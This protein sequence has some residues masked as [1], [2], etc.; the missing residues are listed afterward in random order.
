MIIKN[1]DQPSVYLRQ[2][3][4]LNRR[5]AGHHP[6]K[7]KV[8]QMYR[9]HYSGYLGER[10]LHYPLSFIRHKPYA[11]LFDVRLEDFNHTYFQI[12]CLLLTPHFILVLEAKNLSGSFVYNADF[13]FLE[14]VKDEK[15]SAMNDPVHQVFTQRNKLEEW[16]STHKFPTLPL[17]ARFISAN[18]NAIFRTS[19]KDYATYVI[20][21]ER[22]PS[23]INSFWDEY[24]S[25]A[26]TTRQFKKLYSTILQHHVTYFPSI[27]AQLHI[28]RKDILRRVYCN[29]CDAFS[30]R[31]RNSLWFCPYCNTSSNTAHQSSL[32]D[33]ALLFH[34]HI[35][36]AEARSFLDV[37]SR[38]VIKRLLLKENFPTTGTRK[39]TRYDLTSL[40]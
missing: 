23:M 5:L 16:L 9:N 40:L 26:I 36:N 32:T 14:K 34:Q 30:Y 15:E 28:D 21:M 22:L 18:P 31:R 29:K 1:N 7:E 11:I 12:D 17:E 6:K 10:A 4:A 2:L 25:P 24:P 33:Y 38:D 35:S 13:G 19:N 39:S 27:L 20:R 8:A 37:A 3:E